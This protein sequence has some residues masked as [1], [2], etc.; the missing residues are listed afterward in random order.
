[1][2]SVAPSS[3][4]AEPSTAPSSFLAERRAYS[5]A[6]TERWRTSARSSATGYCG[7]MG[8]LQRSTK[9]FKRN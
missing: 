8:E 2:P 9:G 4:L 5:N 7:N 6:A 3:S 1:V